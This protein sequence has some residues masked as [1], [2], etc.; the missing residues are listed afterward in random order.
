MFEAAR[1]FREMP[2]RDAVSW[3]TLIGGYA[4]LRMYN[5]A[6]D[7]FW[8]MQENGIRARAD[9]CIDSRGLCRDG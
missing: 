6:L 7:V 9:D 1:I 8:E 3:N 4:K 2:E 5:Q